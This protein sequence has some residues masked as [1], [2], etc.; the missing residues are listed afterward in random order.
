MA[1]TKYRKLPRQTGINAASCVER[2]EPLTLS[3]VMVIA[4]AVD[5]IASRSVKPFQ[6]RKKFTM[7][8]WNIHRML[9]SSKVHILGL[10]SWDLS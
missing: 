1:N 8:T 5:T 3:T 6:L 4:D 9:Q 7:G 10:G 2:F